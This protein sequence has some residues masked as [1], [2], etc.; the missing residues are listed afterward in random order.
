MLEKLWK[1]DTSNYDYWNSILD[2]KLLTNYLE[3]VKSK[4]ENLAKAVSAI[5]TT[6]TLE[7]KSKRD[8][9]MNYYTIA[10]ANNL[11]T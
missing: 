10:N 9:L 4:N 3:K 11:I 1:N 5:E 8:N 6:H 2:N 7:N